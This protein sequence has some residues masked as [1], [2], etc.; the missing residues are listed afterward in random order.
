MIH[1]IF[2]NLSVNIAASP[3]DDPTSIPEQIEP[4]PIDT[5]IPFIEE[6]WK[7][8]DYAYG[9]LYDSMYSKL[10]VHAA[11]LRQQLQSCN[12]ARLYQQ[13]EQDLADVEDKLCTLLLKFEE[14][15]P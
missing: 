5:I 15:A 7:D 10:S 14:S 12:N 8:E 13:I 11:Q 4:V 1:T 2:C 9:E 6:E 3:T